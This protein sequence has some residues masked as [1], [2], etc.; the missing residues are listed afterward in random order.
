M[1][2]ALTLLLGICI[3]V[4][5]LSIAL[6]ITRD[7][8]AARGERRFVRAVAGSVETPKPVMKLKIVEGGLKTRR[9]A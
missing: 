7:V 8:R 4:L 6:V 1:T 9:I 5:L 3:G 2:T